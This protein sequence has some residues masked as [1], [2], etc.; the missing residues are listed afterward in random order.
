MAASRTET[1]ARCRRARTRAHPE[2]R[3]GLGIQRS[4]LEARRGS[5]SAERAA[6]SDC[7]ARSQRAKAEHQ[8]GTEVQRDVGPAGPEQPPA[9]ADEVVDGELDPRGERA[10]GRARASP[11]NGSS[12][13]RRIWAHCTAKRN[14]LVLLALTPVM[15][16]SSR[17]E[18]L[19]A[20]CQPVV[21]RQA[22]RRSSGASRTV[23]ASGAAS[24]P[25]GS[26]I[27][28]ILRSTCAYCRGS[29]PLTYGRP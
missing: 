19:L 23:A 7:N 26:D 12:R 25:P 27:R 21:N 17:V 18:P 15:H 5:R 9:A 29:G 8:A 1:A 24:P 20:C 22:A 6:H 3:P 16:D 14:L 28:R 4:G 13:D 11:A 10:A 2:R